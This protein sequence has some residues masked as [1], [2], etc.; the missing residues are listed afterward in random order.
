MQS[1]VSPHCTTLNWHPRRGEDFTSQSVHHKHLLQHSQHALFPGEANSRLSPAIRPVTP[2]FP[3]GTAWSKW[4]NTKFLKPPCSS[5]PQF[6]FYHKLTMD[7]TKLG[8]SISRFLHTLK[9]KFQ[10]KLFCKL[11][12]GGQEKQVLSACKF[13]TS[14]FPDFSHSHA[15]SP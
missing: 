9:D 8:T 1:Q 5:A 14:T 6:C 10:T 12:S 15:H 7:R 2:V 3:G 11:Y 4:Q 13:Q